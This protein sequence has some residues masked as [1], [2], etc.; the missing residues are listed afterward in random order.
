MRKNK[1][2]ALMNLL[3]IELIAENTITY[4][5]GCNEH[6]RAQVLIQLLVNCKWNMH[7]FDVIK[8]SYE[9]YVSWTK[10]LHMSISTEIQK[11][12]NSVSHQLS[13]EQ[14]RNKGMMSELIKERNLHIQQ[15]RYSDLY[16]SI[17]YGR[18][19]ILRWISNWR[20]HM[21]RNIWIVLGFSSGFF[22]VHNDNDS[23][24][25]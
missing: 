13:N 19:E 15:F 2:N 23:K 16:L 14:K 5:Y 1:F 18:N 17:H 8:L 21:I 4:T 25:R 20:E 9:E 6:A 12:K 11:K 3:L 7:I 10:C 24:F 22:D